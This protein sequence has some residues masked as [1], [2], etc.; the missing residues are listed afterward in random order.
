MLTG[1]YSIVLMKSR[2]R[3]RRQ[4]VRHRHLLNMLCL[5]TVVAGI[6]QQDRELCSSFKG[7]VVDPEKLQAMLSAA[8]EGAYRIRLFASPAGFCVDSLFPGGL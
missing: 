8:E 6:N 7:N 1:L 2:E 4:V 3:Y 5:L